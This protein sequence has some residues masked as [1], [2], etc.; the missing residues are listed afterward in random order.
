M[1]AFVLPAF[2]VQS[3]YVFCTNG[4]R[5]VFEG[6][7]RYTP[8]MRRFIVPCL[9]LLFVSAASSQTIPAG[10]KTIKD[11]KGAC[12]IAVPPEWVP[13]GGTTGAAVWK[14]STVAIAVVTSQPGQEFKPLSEGQ[15]SALEIPKGRLFENTAKRIFYQDK[16]SAGPE[17][18]N[19]Y[20]ASVPAGKT[21]TCSFHVR[22][23]P[24]LPAETARKIAL[25]LGPAV[26]EATDPV[27][28]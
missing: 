1:H 17:D 20:S 8:A 3:T 11:S 5:L 22:F 24:E 4:L 15:V 21:A 14:E 2:C 16:V 12:Q 28:P 25:S 13:L 7:W 26:G 23:V 10:W 18:P 19:A 9:V 27:V 6:G